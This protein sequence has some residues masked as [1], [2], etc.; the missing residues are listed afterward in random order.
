MG[1]ALLSNI[2]RNS[3]QSGKKISDKKVHLGG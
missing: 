1:A 3:L 2:I